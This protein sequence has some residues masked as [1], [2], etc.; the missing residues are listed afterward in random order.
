MQE[1]WDNELKGSN[2]VI[3]GDYDNIAITKNG[4]SGFCSAFGRVIIDSGCHEWKFKIHKTN[5]S[6]LALM[7][8][9]RKD[10]HCKDVIKS[11]ISKNYFGY[12]WNAS[13]TRLTN[14]NKP[15][16]RYG[17]KIKASDEVVMSFNIDER[18]LRYIV[19]GN[20]YGIAVF[21]K[22]IDKNEKYR[23]GITLCNENKVEIL[24]YQQIEK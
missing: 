19:N 3:Q 21:D 24:S 10:K 20:D 12:A 7:I 22:K 13:Q 11:F 6:P 16:A 5:M 18:I 4:T 2:I 15:G 14:S 8:G 23:M 17:R 9:I 1:T